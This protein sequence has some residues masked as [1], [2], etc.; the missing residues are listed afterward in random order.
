MAKFKGSVV[1]L[2][3]TNL[4]ALFYYKYLLESYNKEVKY[5]PTQYYDEIDKK[6]IDNNISNIL[7]DL[8]IMMGVNVEVEVQ[9]LIKH[10]NERI[11][12][13]QKTVYHGFVYNTIHDDIRDEGLAK[14]YAQT[15]TKQIKE[16]QEP[17]ND[18]FKKYSVHVYNG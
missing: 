14:K 9:D 7:S 8:N 3:E 18:I 11:N 6:G 1:V 12:E 2:E 10:I 5:A 15:I 4:P 13:I 16:H 17:Y